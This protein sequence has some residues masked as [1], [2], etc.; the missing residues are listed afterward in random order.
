M[1]DTKWTDQQQAAIDSRG[2]TL[3]LSA[4]AGSGKTAVLVERV[5]RRILD[6]KNPIDADKIVVVTFSNAAARE[7]RERI[8]ARLSQLLREKPGDLQLL[9]Q[10]VLLTKAQISTIHSFCLNLIRDHFETLDL[11]PD[12]RIADENELALLRDQVLNDTIEAYYAGE[13]GEEF[14]DLVELLSSGRDDRRVGQTVLKLYDFVRSHPFYEDWL[15]EKLAMYDPGQPVEQTVWGRV[16]LDYA[17]DALRYSVALITEAID[18]IQ[19]DE[20]MAKAYLTPFKSDYQQLLEIQSAVE[21]GSWDEIC[22]ALSRFETIRLGQLRGY[23]DDEKKEQVKTLRAKV[24]KLVENLRDK[25]FC[26]TSMQFSED[27]ADLRPKVELLFR[28]T[29]DFDRELIRRKQADKMVDFSDLEQYTIRLLMEKTPD[30]LKKTGLAR[31]LSTGIEEIYIDEYQDT[32]YAQ[33][34]IF[35]AVSNN[36]QNLFMVGDVKQ[37]IYRFRQAVP[38]L[39]MQKKS[40]YSPFDGVHYPAKLDLNRNFRSRSEVTGCINYVFRSLMS[41]QVGELEYGAGEALVPGAQYPKYPAAGCELR[42]LNGEN[43]EDTSVLEAE[44]VAHRIQQ[45]LREGYQVTEKDGKMRPLRMGD[46]CILL[47]ATKNKAEIYRRALAERGLHGITDG[48][49]GYLDTLEISS[50]LALLQVVD[51]PLQDIPLVQALTSVMFGFTT[52]D[53]A[54]LRCADRK[55]TVYS[56]LQKYAEM[57]HEKSARFLQ[58]LSKLRGYAASLPADQLLWRLYEETGFLALASSLE[59]GETRGANLR[60]LVSYAKQYEQTGCRGLSGFVRF[61]TRIYERG[62]DLAGAPSSPGE[63][64]VRIM[65]IHKS[66]GLEFPVV[67]LCDNAKEFNRM[68]LRQN[69]LLHSRLGFACVRR[70]MELLCQFTTLPMEAVRLELERE[71]LS[72]ELRVLYVAMTRAKEKLILTACLKKPARKLSSLAASCPPDG[73]IPPY[74]VRGVSSYA[75]WLMLC[76]LRHPAG[77]EIRAVP[78]ASAPVIKEDCRWE[79]YLESAQEKETAVSHGFERASKPDQS[80]KKQLERRLSYSYSNLGSTL[81]P[82]KFAISEIAK[83]KAA[84]QYYFQKRPR[85]EMGGA[86]TGAE[87][88]NAMHKFMQFAN[89]QKAACSVVEEL[90]RLEREHYL[91]PEERRGVEVEKL[92]AFFNSELARRIFS[93]Q[94]VYRELR[95]LTGLGREELEK[96]MP[97]PKTTD[98]TTVQGVAD[99]VF[100]EDGQGVIVDYKTDRHITPAELKKR[101]RVQLELYRVILQKSLEVPIKECVIYSLDLGQTIP[102]LLK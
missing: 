3:L 8:G 32:N 62:S 26:A 70:N 11:P 80:L 58:L 22:A 17:A 25:Q 33:E 95:F 66:K 6:S 45:L 4:A 101:Y 98:K 69:T 55:G 54:E 99:C 7:M 61:L 92:A 81:L 82:N 102:I 24:K 97:Y 67:F 68:D 72:E 83:G 56:A 40:S 42:L 64:A 88:G 37:S 85:F 23:A 5:I 29:L 19:Q 39:F 94:K 91:T 44:Y 93:A 15:Q 38:E 31:A 49:C 50:V 78:G 79:I 20:A 73:P 57:G 16:I 41:P 87:R 100:I 35:S 52:D 75:D 34:M 12:F 63:D 65:S 14:A 9:R 46:V 43:A 60:L 13:Q 53:L 51:N 89:Y 30:G 48:T 27:I 59:G 74:V 47:R 84:V 36:G 2:G 28:L 76:A 96:Y 10:Q 1:A 18:R 77:D 71:M 21:G 86:L 90:D